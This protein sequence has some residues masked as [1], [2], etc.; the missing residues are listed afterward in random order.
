MPCTIANLSSGACLIECPGLLASIGAP[1]HLTLAEGPAIPGTIAW[2]MGQSTG[3]CF[4]QPVGDD[5]VRRYALDDW[6]LRSG[7]Q[8]VPLRVPQQ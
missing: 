3:I 5:L 4:L 6:P 8:L 7:A 2:Q 1:V